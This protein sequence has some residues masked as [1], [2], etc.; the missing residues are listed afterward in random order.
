MVPVIQL[1]M[2]RNRDRPKAKQAC[3]G[4]GEDSV[5]LSTQLYGFFSF[6]SLQ[7]PQIKELGE[8][9]FNYV[10]EG[11]ELLKRMTEGLDPE[12]CT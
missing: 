5:R 3:G 11:S 1:A 7:F 10:F 4:G 2:L 6:L 9:A 12:T 8:A